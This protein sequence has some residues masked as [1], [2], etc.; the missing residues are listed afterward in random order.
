MWTFDTMNHARRWLEWCAW[1]SIFDVQSRE[2]IPN[3][4]IHSSGSSWSSLVMLSFICYNR[5]KKCEQQY[6]YLLLVTSVHLSSLSIILM[7]QKL[8]IN[9]SQVSHTY[10]L[11]AEPSEHVLWSHL[12]VAQTALAHRQHSLRSTE[13]QLHR[14]PILQHLPI[15]KN[16]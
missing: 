7:K 15:H 6:Y 10:A 2:H 14:G 16:I 3:K 9:Y 13:D 1:R 8:S 11:E 12:A 5:W 4:K